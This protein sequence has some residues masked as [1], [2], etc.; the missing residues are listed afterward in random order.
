MLSLFV[1]RQAQMDYSPAYRQE[2]AL[3]TVEELCVMRLDYTWTS[4][5]RVTVHH[6]WS[7][8]MDELQNTKH[9]D[10]ADMLTQTPFDYLQHG[11]IQPYTD[12][13]P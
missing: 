3:L 10:A 4:D 9:P 12:P 8:L 5:A 7:S 13:H 2:H 11:G 6:A 1:A